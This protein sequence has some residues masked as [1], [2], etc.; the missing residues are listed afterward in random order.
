M[1]Q[2]ATIIMENIH[3]VLVG[4]GISLEPISQITKAE[5]SNDT[6]VIYDKFIVVREIEEIDNL[7][8]NEYLIYNT[9]NSEQYID[10]IVNEEVSSLK[11]EAFKEFFLDK[12]EDSMKEYKHTF[13]KNENGEYYWYST[14]PVNVGTTNNKTTKLSQTEL[15]ELETY[16][17][18]NDLEHFLIEDYE[19]VREARLD[20]GILY[21]FITQNGKSLSENEEIE[22]YGKVLNSGN[23]YKIDKSKV[24]EFLKN[25]TGY[26]LDEFKNGKDLGKKTRIRYS[27]KDNLYYMSTAGAIDT[28]SGKLVS[29]EKDGNKYTLNYEK[30]VLTLNKVENTYLVVSHILKK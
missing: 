3:I 16:I 27:E 12:Y 4:S 29:A 25:N 11:P 26:T 20:E 19:D 10:K 22:Y 17:I 30:S 8:G 21:P 23:A 5:R 18:N 28:I 2:V 24:E 1:E 7:I 13:K 9:T 14:E 6:I 15:K